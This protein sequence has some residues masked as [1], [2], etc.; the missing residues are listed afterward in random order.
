[1]HSILPKET[2]RAMLVLA[3]LKLTR[4]ELAQVWNLMQK[5]SLQEFINTLRT[6]SQEHFNEKDEMQEANALPSDL[7]TTSTSGTVLKNVIYLLRHDSKLSNKEIVASLTMLFST[8][9]AADIVS[10]KYDNRKSISEWLDQLARI[11]GPSELL[12]AATIIRNQK[13]HQTPN[14]WPLEGEKYE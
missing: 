4:A 10:I 3:S 13:V 7:L 2:V 11:V 1:M 14:P 9:G 8:K 5:L 6:L 12:R